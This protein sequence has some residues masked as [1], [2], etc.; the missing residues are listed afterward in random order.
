[1]IMSAVRPA[2]IISGAWSP[3]NK[4]VKN[5]NCIGLSGKVTV[6]RV[7]SRQY[8]G[9]MITLTP[10]GMM[11]IE[12]TPEHQL[13]VSHM[14]MRR[15]HPSFCRHL[16]CSHKNITGE[17]VL[18]RN[19][20]TIK[21]ATPYWI[22]AS[23]ITRT[24]KGQHYNG[25]YL[26]VPRLIGTCNTHTISLED[27][28][29]RHGK[30][31][32]Y[33]KNRRISLPLSEDVAW[34]FGLYV[35]EGCSDSGSGFIVFTLGKDER[36]LR[37]KI[38]DIATNLG[39]TVHARDKQWKTDVRIFSRVLSRAM[40]VWFGNHA[41]QKHIPDFI[42]Y[43]NDL[44]KVNAFLNGYLAGDGHVRPASSRNSYEHHIAAT[45]SKILALQLQLMC[46]RLGR[47]ESIIPSPQGKRNSKVGH[48]SILKPNAKLHRMYVLYLSRKKP[49]DAPL[50]SKVRMFKNFMLVPIR[51]I[52]R[53]QYGC[54]VWNVTTA[55]GTYLASNAIV[56]NCGSEKLLS[57]PIGEMK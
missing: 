19:R 47:W 50:F 5:T 52:S 30:V 24:F 6:N 35:A 17:L 48:S 43:H 29:V 23:H 41:S 46:A 44:K 55:D 45:V 27:Y 31:I 1:M 28:F 9:V 49:L 25:H 11:P 32:V 20:F 42:L 56:H 26:V 16:W 10:T 13:L 12:L 4:L 53:H 21:Y 39:Y 18:K 40:P 37:N 57:M 22:D 54:R 2:T 36:F 3:I 14:T 15:F 51:K 33:K 34:L 7:M 8:N 38:R